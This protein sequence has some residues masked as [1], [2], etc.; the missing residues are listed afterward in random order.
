M[1]GGNRHSNFVFVD[2]HCMVKLFLFTMATT[3]RKHMEVTFHIKYQ[4]LQELGTF[5]TDTGMD[6]WKKNWKES[7]EEK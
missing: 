2:K 6:P 5:T 4:A 1:E 3:K 7:S